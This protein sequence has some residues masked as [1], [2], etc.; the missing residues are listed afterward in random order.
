MLLT[1]CKEEKEEIDNI[2]TA[3]EANAGPDQFASLG[4]TVL[5]D[6][7]GSRDPDGDEI[8][9]HWTITS[10]PLA[11]TASL[12]DNKIADPT[13]VADKTGIF[14]LQLIVNDGTIDSEPSN[15]KITVKETYAGASLVNTIE[16]IFIKP[17]EGNV[18]FCH[19]ATIYNNYLYLVSYAEL[20]TYPSKIAKIDLNTDAIEPGYPKDL[21][22]ADTRLCG[23]AFDPDDNSFWVSQVDAGSILHYS[24]SC[25]YLEEIYVTAGNF[26]L[27]DVFIRGEQI[28]VPYVT[29]DNSGDYKNVF[30]SIFNKNNHSLETNFKITTADLVDDAQGW[31]D[32]FVT[33]E[34]IYIAYGFSSENIPCILKTDLVGGS[35]EAITI[36]DG[37]G[38]MQELVGVSILNDKMYVNAKS[39]IYVASLA[40]DIFNKWE[41][42]KPI[43]FDE[44]I[45]E[46]IELHNDKIYISSS[47]DAENGPVN[48]HVLIYEEN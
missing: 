27:G 45:Y 46:R 36:N 3:P 41:I 43:N 33:G 35:Q 15:T 22:N 13:F 24:S 32:I 11:S 40:G 5:L 28:F 10:K 1:T 42:D 14:T 2:N 19:G 39:T 38:I 6:G 44:G 30:V 20:M 9:Y 47:N 26:T 21:T 31:A 7:S 37:S 29:I 12:F 25:N 48:P 18:I 4:D 16:D 17:E 34:S 8:S 23:I